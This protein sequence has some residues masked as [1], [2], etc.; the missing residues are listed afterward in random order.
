MEPTLPKEFRAAGVHCGIKHDPA[1]PDLALVV[2]DR[3]ATAAGVYT[4]NRVCA[5][6]VQLDRARTP[7]ESVRAV[8]I[9]SGNANACTGQQ[10]WTD[11][12][13]MA[14]LTAGAIGAAEEQVLVLS[15]GIIGETLPMDKVAQGIEQ[16][17]QRLEAS[18]EATVAA[19]D[20]M[21]TTDRYRKVAGRQVKLGSHTVQLLGMAKGAGMIAPNMATMLA[22]LLTDAA[23][24]PQVAQE[25]LR[26]AVD[27]TF[28]LISVDG[29]TSTNDSVLLLANGASGVAAHEAQWRKAFR[30]ALFE[31][32]V[33]LARAI[34]ADGEGSTHLIT[35]FVR[36]CA[37]EAD[38]V[39]IARA[40]ANSPLV[41]TAIAGADP[42]W[43]RIV[44]AAGYAGVPFQPERV[45]L[46]VNGHLLYKNGVPVQFD[47]EVVSQSIRT[48]RETTIDLHFQEGDASARF[49]TSDLTAEY[50]RI[51]SEYHT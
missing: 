10:G 16:A 15:T 42:N 41:K 8:V 31:V 51:N 12:V 5:A 48:Q 28:N 4:R 17:A 39:A 22:V 20:A 50:V 29:H 11:A 6:P 33:E 36:G 19:A 32:C 27:G 7:S 38:A 23:L 44:S 25:E 3:R 14:R 26:A 13:Q 2:S 35:I 1:K 30:D 21:L 45:G 24:P 40:V 49:W 43:G 9:N 18:A 37:T 46:Y 34:P 47:A